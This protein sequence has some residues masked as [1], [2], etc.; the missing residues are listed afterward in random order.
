MSGIL[1]QARPE[2]GLVYK[3]GSDIVVVR[4][5]LQQFFDSVVLLETGDSAGTSEIDFTH[6]AA[7]QHLEQ[8]VV[9]K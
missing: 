9:A 8:A 2:F 3:A 6:A 7:C 1:L 5:L 4:E